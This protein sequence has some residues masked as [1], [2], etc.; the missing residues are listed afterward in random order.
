MWDY[1][2]STTNFKE[3]SN[4]Q[5]KKIKDATV[6]YTEEVMVD[7]ANRLKEMIERE[8]HSKI[9]LHVNG[10]KV[11]NVGMTVDG[12]RQKRD[13]ASKVGVVFVVA[14]RTGEVLDYVVKSLSCHEIDVM[15]MKTKV[16]Q[17]INYG[18]KFT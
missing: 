18:M 13:H 4:E 1:W 14:V 2:A 8:E 3:A 9:H 11:A 6:K 7:A 17:N 10:N 15:K 16:P 5:L 12:T